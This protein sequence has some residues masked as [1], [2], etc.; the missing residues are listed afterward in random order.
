MAENPNLERLSES[1]RSHDRARL[2]H[3]RRSSSR[4]RGWQLTGTAQQSRFSCRGRR[5]AP[6]GV[7]T[8]VEPPV[9]GRKGA[10]KRQPPQEEAQ[11]NPEG[12]VSDQGGSPRQP[13]QQRHGHKQPQRETKGHAEQPPAARV[14]GGALEG[15]SVEQAAP[16]HP[17]KAGQNAHEPRA[18]PRPPQCIERSKGVQNGEHWQRG[19]EARESA[20]QHRPLRWAGLKTVGPQDPKHHTPQQLHAAPCRG[21]RFEKVPSQTGARDVDRPG[22]PGADRG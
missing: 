2:G 13:L 16:C 11:K 4:G 20:A 10:A 17:S 5:G 19:R 1:W 12:R 6:P 9:Q 15:Q 7:E 3:L 18:C 8:H 22:L 14:I 21:A